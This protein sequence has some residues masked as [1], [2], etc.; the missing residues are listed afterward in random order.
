M[1]DQIP[2]EVSSRR[3]QKLLDL[4]TE[5]SHEINASYVG[6]TTTVLIDDEVDAGEGYISGR[7]FENLVVRVP[8]ASAKKGFA[9]VYLKESLGWALEGEIIN[10]EE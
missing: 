6:K 5:I 4:Q 8:R 2:P 7:S 1:E 3:F 9:K 10:T